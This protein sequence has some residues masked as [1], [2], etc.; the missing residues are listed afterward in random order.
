MG[1]SPSLSPS[2]R[3]L[4]ARLGGLTTAARHDPREITAPARAAFE[5]RFYEGIAEDLPPAERDRRA[6]ANRKIYFTRL[7]L[8]S[9]AT[10]RKRRGRRGA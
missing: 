10:R 2:E 3:S 1:R 9:A 4:R 5:Q 7:S 6:A 8:A